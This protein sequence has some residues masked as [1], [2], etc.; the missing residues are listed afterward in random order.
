MYLMPTSARGARLAVDTRA[1]R[2]VRRRMLGVDDVE[3]RRF[4]ALYRM[5]N[6]GSPRSNVMP[7]GTFTDWAGRKPPVRIVNDQAP[8]STTTTTATPSSTPTAATKPGT[9]YTDANANIW[10]YNGT[11][12]TI[13]GS[14][15]A[16]G[17]ITQPNPVP[18]NVSV[19]APAASSGGYQSILDW[20]TQKTL[21]PQVPNWGVAAAIGLLGMKLTAARGGR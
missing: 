15:A 1:I 3:M 2:R 19:S 20:L 11:N 13:T 21:I 17:Q 7:G 16:G 8:P 5:A 9:Q 18:V 4:T 14:A 12:W 10:T 6:G